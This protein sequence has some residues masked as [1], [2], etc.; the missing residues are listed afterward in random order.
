MFH[1]DDSVR[2]AL[3]EDT[4]NQLREI[5]ISVKTEGAGWDVAYDRAL[6]EP[7]MWGWERTRRWNFIIFITR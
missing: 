7:L 3:A 2:Q 6:S 4:A 5:G 1:P